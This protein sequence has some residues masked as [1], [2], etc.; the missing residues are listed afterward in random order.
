[1]TLSK[2]E[3][4][5]NPEA[6]TKKKILKGVSGYALPGEVTYIIG[7]SGSG[8]TSLLN[9]ISDRTSA[10][11]GRSLSGTVLVNDKDK[12]DYKMF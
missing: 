6:S 1:M 2:K 9:M 12:L 10:G 7:S 4:Q 3:R 8:K 11:H 5:A